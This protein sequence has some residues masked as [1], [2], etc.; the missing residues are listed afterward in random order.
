M[1]DK[2]I[3]CLLLVF[4]SLAF[5]LGTAQA[6]LP[7]AQI[8][9]E[10]PVL[11]GITW[12]TGNSTEVELKRSSQDE[13]QLFISLE[14][15]YEGPSANFLV[16]EKAA[17]RSGS[18]PIYKAEVRIQAETTPVRIMAVD[19]TGEIRAQNLEIH[20]PMFQ[21][22]Q[23]DTLGLSPS[24][25]RSPFGIKAVAGLNSI[26]VNQSSSRGLSEWGIYFQVDGTYRL[27]KSQWLLEGMGWVTTLPFGYSDSLKANVFGGEAHISYL[28]SWLNSPW[29]L[30][31]SLGFYYTTL[32]VTQQLFG[33]QDL[34]AFELFPKLEYNLP[35]GDPLHLTAKYLPVFSGFSSLTF[36]SRVIEVSA[37]W[38]HL[39]GKSSSR[40]ISVGFNWT[41]IQ[42]KGSGSSFLGAVHFQSVGL[43]LGYRW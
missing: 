34:S 22:V 12:I 24:P 25:S 37:G 20:F 38:D 21:K 7:E 8:T 14:W 39:V 17:V 18:L 31:L 2:R 9:F 23:E 27:G 28:K 11:E 33:F 1:N 6:A 26:R 16:D 30:S 43:N 36:D 3:Y 10:T 42:L 40:A 5:A 29:S 41:D 4:V 19:V 15:K 13:V 35:N 32:D